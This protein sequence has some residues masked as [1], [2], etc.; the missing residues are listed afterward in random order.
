[1]TAVIKTFRHKGLRKFWNRGDASGLPAPLLRRLQVRLVA[2]NEASAPAEMNIS[3][4]NFHELKGDRKGVFS[5]HVN[6]PYCI[7]F[8]WDD[9]AIDVDFENYH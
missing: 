5:V 6:G 1:L 2:L 4:F 3:G 8:G 9:G 7:T